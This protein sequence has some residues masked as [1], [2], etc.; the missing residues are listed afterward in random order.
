MEKEVAISM[1]RGLRHELDC[2]VRDYNDKIQFL[3][4]KN[5]GY[6]YF[7]FY[8]YFITKSQY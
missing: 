4:L 8:F 7:Y 6:Y 5:E 1:A 3:E 2:S